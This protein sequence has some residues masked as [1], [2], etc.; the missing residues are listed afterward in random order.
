M[1]KP[2]RS[3][4]KLGRTP[5]P[6]RPPS[7]GL[8][9]GGG[10]K[11]GGGCRPPHQVKKRGAADTSEIP[12]GAGLIHVRRAYPYRPA[13]TGSSFILKDQT[14]HFL[15]TNRGNFGRKFGGNNFVLFDWSVQWASRPQFFLP[16]F[17][18]EF[19]PRPKIENLAK[20][21]VKSVKIR[22]SP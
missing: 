4:C 19:Q 14:E 15:E 10:C 20:S 5:A 1:D 9:F 21:G 12:G 11:L 7:G 16:V 13:I 3:A 6:P 22:N 17:C 2:T 18:F 8:K